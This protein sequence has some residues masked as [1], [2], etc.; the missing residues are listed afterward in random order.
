M[1]GNDIPPSIAEASNSNLALFTNNSQRVLRALWATTLQIKIVDHDCAQVICALFRN[2]QQPLAIRC[3]LNPPYRSLE[4][5]CVNKFAGLDLP[6]AH[7][8][9]CPASGDICG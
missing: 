2:A 5:P 8:V 7:S 3:E 9:V 6:Q 4:F 1:T